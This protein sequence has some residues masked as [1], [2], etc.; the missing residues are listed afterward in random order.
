MLN[1]IQARSTMWGGLSLFLTTATLVGYGA[2]SGRAQS[3]SQAD[4]ALEENATAEVQALASYL[5]QA[6]GVARTSAQVLGAVKDSELG[7]DLSRESAIGI[8]SM[9]LRENPNFVSVFTCW[10]ENAFDDLDEAYA[11]VEGHDATGRFMPMVRLKEGER[12][13]QEI[14]PLSDFSPEA[15][16]YAEPRTSRLSHVTPPRQEKIGNRQFALTRLTVPIEFDGEFFGVLGVDLD[17][18]P[19]QV[20][21]DDLDTYDGTAILTLVGPQNKLFARGGEPALSG[22][23]LDTQATG[24]TEQ[25]QHVKVAR[26]KVPGGTQ[27]ISAQLAVPEDVLTQAADRQT[28]IQLGLGLVVAALGFALLWFSSGAIARPVRKV[29]QR[30]QEVSREGGDL[31]H[32]L[33]VEGPL[34]VRLLAEGFNG[35]LGKTRDLVSRIAAC[36]QEVSRAADSLEIN[37]VSMQETAEHTSDIAY[38]AS[39][40]SENVQ[41][42]IASFADSVEKMSQSIGSIQESTV[43]SSQIVHRSVE[44]SRNAEHDIAS[45]SKNSQD[46]ERAIGLI[47]SIAE[48]TNLLALNATIEAARAGE[49][50]KGFAVVASE[51][52]DLAIE[53]GKAT[54]EIAGTVETI[55]SDT[56][57]AI[58]SIRE[59]SETVLLIEE[60]SSE[61]SSA[62][63]EQALASEEAVTSSRSAQDLTADVSRHVGDASESASKSQNCAA[64]T[65]SLSACVQETAS[66]LSAIVGEFKF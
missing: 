10:E 60:A 2:W 26:L 22:T 33:P 12:D 28:R 6:L 53:T 19:L 24:S 49:A 38:S 11:D 54:S 27:T 47:S 14:L 57:R 8:L 48:Q 23:V 4:R 43:N 46:I 63:G 40:A 62:I 50:G 59:V 7:M 44:L 41:G 37:A 36:T 13:K 20:L 18:A 45:L 34:E 9:A 52:K 64:Q 16:Y 30:L 21:A 3:L 1:S 56:E 65:H 17:L 5:G 32:G 66:Q 31:T 58:A 29:A 35:F 61:V 25:E 51:V 39:Q 55:L 15:E 42:T